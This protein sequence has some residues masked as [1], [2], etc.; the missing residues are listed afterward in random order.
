MLAETNKE[1]FLKWVDQLFESGFGNKTFQEYEWKGKQLPSIFVLL[2]RLQENLCL[3]EEI[4]ICGLCLMMRVAEKS[5][6]AQE[7]S[8]YK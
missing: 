1:I 4:L 7:N 2:Q 3:N 6:R 8:I 5:L